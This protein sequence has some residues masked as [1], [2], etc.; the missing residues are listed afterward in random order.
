MTAP[1]TRS[2]SLIWQAKNAGG[3][4]HQLELLKHLLP[5]EPH[6]LLNIDPATVIKPSL[7]QL[8]VGALSVESTRR[9]SA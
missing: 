5:T 8:K 3:V 2:G 6:R 1:H 4:S 7:T 9:A